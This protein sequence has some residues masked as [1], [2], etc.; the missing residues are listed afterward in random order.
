MQSFLFLLRSCLS[1]CVAALS[2]LLLSSVH[3]RCQPRRSLLFSSIFCLI[4]IGQS[5]ALSMSVCSGV[6]LQ[7]AHCTVSLKNLTAASISSSVLRQTFKV[8]LWLMRCLKAAHHRPLEVWDHGFI[9]HSMHG[10]L[11]FFCVCVVRWV[12]WLDLERAESSSACKLCKRCRTQWGRH[13]R[14]T[15]WSR[16]E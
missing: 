15:C 12:Q 16:A 8:N 9:S 6:A 2:N 14:V 1:S 4:N 3:S 11:Y 13:R 7:S 10:S 5:F